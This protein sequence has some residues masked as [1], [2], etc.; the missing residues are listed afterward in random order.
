MT[1]TTRQAENEFKI[2]QTQNVKG[3]PMGIYNEK[4]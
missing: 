4:T 3:T 2:K 1:G